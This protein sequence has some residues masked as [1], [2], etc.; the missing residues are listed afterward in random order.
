MQVLIIQV[1]GQLSLAH[2]LPTPRVSA[3]QQVLVPARA[4]GCCHSTAQYC[5]ETLLE[6][7]TGRQRLPGAGLETDTRWTGERETWKANSKMTSHS[8]SPFTP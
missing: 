4:A 5:T 1:Q 3:Q 7:P 2:R 8:G 6:G